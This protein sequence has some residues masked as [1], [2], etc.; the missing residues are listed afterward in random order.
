MAERMTVL[1]VVDDATILCSIT[2]GFL[3]EL[4]NQLFTRRGVAGKY[5]KYK[6]KGEFHQTEHEDHP[7]KVG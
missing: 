2:K 4:Y 3:D 7:R 1:F 5:L 6:Q